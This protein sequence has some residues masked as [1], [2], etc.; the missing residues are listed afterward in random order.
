[1]KELIMFELEDMFIEVVRR[2]TDYS[3][4]MFMGEIRIALYSNAISIDE[5]NF[6]FNAYMSAR[7]K[8]V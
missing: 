1:M 5:Y 3:D 4:G 8:E 7:F 2:H 6:I